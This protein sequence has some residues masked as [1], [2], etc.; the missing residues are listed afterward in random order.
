MQYEKDRLGFYDYDYDQYVGQ[1]ENT[2]DAKNVTKDIQHT[3]NCV[4]SSDLVE[5]SPLLASNI[6]IE[7]E[8]IE[9]YK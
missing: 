5:E 6:V 8:K 2:L 9:G 4:I 7:V 3:I 1:Y